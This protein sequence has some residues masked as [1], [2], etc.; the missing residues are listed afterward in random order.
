MM[1]VMQSVCPH[2]SPIAWQP[3]IIISTVAKKLASVVKRQHDSNFRITIAKKQH[4]HITAIQLPSSLQYE[5]YKQSVTLS[6]KRGHSA[7]K[8]ISGTGR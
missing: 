6:E 8:L 3:I 5:R 1:R 2:N 7:Q 4:I